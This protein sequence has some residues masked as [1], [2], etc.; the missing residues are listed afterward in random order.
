MP[1]P[2]G[3]YFKLQAVKTSPAKTV[4]FPIY[5]SSTRVQY[6]YVKLM[7]SGPHEVQFVVSKEDAATLMAKKY[8]GSL[9]AHIFDNSRVADGGTAVD[10]RIFPLIPWRAEFLSKTVARVTFK[11]AVG[12]NSVQDWANDVWDASGFVELTDEVVATAPTQQNSFQEY[13]FS[14]VVQVD[15]YDT[16]AGVELHDDVTPSVKEAASVGTHNFRRPSTKWQMLRVHE[17]LCGVVYWWD[18]EDR[19]VHLV[20]ADEDQPD[21]DTFKD[22]KY[23]V[24]EYPNLENN[25]PKVLFN[26]ANYY[27]R[28]ALVQGGFSNFPY[29]KINPNLGLNVPELYKFSDPG[30]V[31]IHYSSLVLGQLIIE[32]LTSSLASAQDL[33]DDHAATYE[34]AIKAAKRTYTAYNRASKRTDWYRLKGFHAVSLGSEI[35]SITYKNQST[36]VDFRDERLPVWPS[37]ATMPTPTI[38]VVSVV[39]QVKYTPGRFLGQASAPHSGTWNV[40]RLLGYTSGQNTYS[41]FALE[42][43]DTLGLFPWLDVGDRVLCLWDGSRG[44]IINSE[45]AAD[46]ELQ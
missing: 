11:L 24:E 7:R 43:E 20:L 38:S 37:L 39:I 36:V 27:F 30:A 9:E 10:I 29:R 13:L 16:W 25:Q 6:N 3:I 31:Q 15:P 28:N 5:Q 18:T 22:P 34:R 8:E 14:G 23:V 21:L 44:V 2:V 17:A 45:L 32:T 40:P 1:D 19:T 4:D 41:P 26:S 35:A 33:I 42:I 46:V 12:G